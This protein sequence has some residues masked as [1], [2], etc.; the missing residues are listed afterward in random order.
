MVT[1]FAILRNHMVERQLAARGIRD[2][3][4]LDAFRSVPRELFVAEGLAAAAYDDRPLPIGAGQT[5]SQPFIVALMI[6]SAAIEAGSNVLEI[7]AGSGYA[8]ALLGRIAG[9][10]TAIER[11]PELADSAA[12][13]LERLGYGNVEIREGDGTLG[14]P[15]RAPFDAILVA[16]TGPEPPRPLL[17]QLAIGGRLVI[18]IGSGLGGQRLVRVTR[19]ADDK[20]DERELCGVRFVP[21][22]GAHGFER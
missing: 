8:A 11:H 7:G 19:A 20:F 6:E 16:A 13:R 14:W 1:D 15:S 17:D 18:P 4:V 5:I 12:R 10:V 2:P 3:A 22:I 21:L 9:Q